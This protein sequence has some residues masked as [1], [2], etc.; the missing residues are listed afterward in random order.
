MEIKKEFFV[1]ERNYKSFAERVDYI[2]ENYT[3]IQDEMKKN[4]LPTKNKFLQDL[5]E[6]LFI[7]FKGGGRVVE[8]AR[9]R[10]ACRQETVSGTESLSHILKTLQIIKFFSVHRDSK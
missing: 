8:G 10:K 6:A 1:A 4:N 7:I 9:L 2:I 5:G 3:H